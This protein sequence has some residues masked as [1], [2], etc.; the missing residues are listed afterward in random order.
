VTGT[1]GTTTNCTQADKC[2]LGALTTAL[3]GHVDTDTADPAISTGVYFALGS[4]VPAPT[5][6]AVDKF[7]FNTF[8]FNFES[9]G[10]FMTTS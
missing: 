4:G 3:D 10:V 5:E 1:E 9:T 2:T 7:V 6:R 8:T